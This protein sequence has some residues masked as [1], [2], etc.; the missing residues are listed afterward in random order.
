M[1]KHQEKLEGDHAAVLA[2]RQNDE[3]VNNA[4]HQDQVNQ[5]LARRIG[6]KDVDVD[7][8]DMEGGCR[9]SKTA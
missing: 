6:F 5:A 4:A 2:D 1:Q 9:S 3:A 8:V 7:A